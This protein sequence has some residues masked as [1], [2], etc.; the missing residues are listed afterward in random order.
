MIPITGHPT[1]LI[2]IPGRQSLA[3]ACRSPPPLRGSRGDAWL[4]VPCCPWPLRARAA[5]SITLLSPLPLSWSGPME[6]MSQPQL[7]RASSWCFQRR[8]AHRTQ[9]LMLAVVELDLTIA[10]RA[11]RQRSDL[12]GLFPHSHFLK[13][14]LSHQQAVPVPQSIL[15]LSC[16][17]GP[18]HTHTHTLVHYIRTYS[19]SPS[20]SFLPTLWGDALPPYPFSPYTLSPIHGGPNAQECFLAALELNDDPG[21]LEKPQSSML[22]VSLCLSCLPFL[23]GVTDG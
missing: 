14:F 17:L 4:P 8:N 15:L 20:S 6:A 21:G 11:H 22:S 23:V 7:V 1:V 10:A 18:A 16:H 5:S 19:K 12:P 2:T 13:M 3:P 9:A